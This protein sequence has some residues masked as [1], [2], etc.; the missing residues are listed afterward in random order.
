MPNER[1]RAALLENGL[2]PGDLAAH[3]TVDHKTVERWVN[4][5]TPYRRHRY[6]IATK[7]G[8]QEQY[9]WPGAL[10]RDQ[11]T[12]ASESELLAIYPHRGDVPRELWT[13]LFESARGEIDILVYVAMFLAEDA[14]LQRILIDKARSGV[15]IRLL[16]GDPDSPALLE[17]SHDEG[18]GDAIAAKVRNALALYRPLRAVEGVQV[19]MHGTVLYNS[20]YRAYGEL[21]VNTHVYGMIAA[22]APLWHLKKVA[23]GELAATYM[24]SF[25]HVWEFSSPVAEG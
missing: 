5:R 12:A 11:V 17:R 15:R 4:G 2:T 14:K 18:I 13:R 24:E 9:L 21:L 8:V 6:A 25:E 3:L 19:R 1:L 23:G 20:I 10:S 22:H 16:L 7:L